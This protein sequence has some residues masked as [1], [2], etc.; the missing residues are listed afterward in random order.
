MKPKHHHKKLKAKGFQA[1]QSLRQLERIHLQIV[2]ADRFE[3]DLFLRSID[4]FERI[5]DE[6]EK[7]ELGHD[8]AACWNQFIHL[9]PWSEKYLAWFQLLAGVMDDDLKDIFTVA[10]LEQLAEEPESNEIL[11]YLWQRYW[12]NEDSQWVLYSCYVTRPEKF[13]KAYNQYRQLLAND[14]IELKAISTAEYT[15]WRD[16]DCL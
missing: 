11:K 8:L 5:M 2:E 1:D 12:N 14:K 9:E 15:R 16:E 6:D 7:Q 13:K 10:A 3:D 4:L